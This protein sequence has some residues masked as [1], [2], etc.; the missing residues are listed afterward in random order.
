MYE[1][2]FKKGLPNRKEKY[3]WQDG[4]YYDGSW[5]DGKKNGSGILYTAASDS[6]IKGIW[7]NGEFI[8]EIVD[9]PYSIITK[10]G[11]TGVNF[12]K[13]EDLIPYRVELVFQKDGAQMRSVN[14]LSLVSSTGQIK[15]S[16]SFSGFENVTFP[17]EGYLE[18]FE[19]SRMGTT[20]IRYELRFKITEEGS[21]KV[22]VRF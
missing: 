20:M 6:S 3:I 11:V 14:Q 2:R 22:I 5:K 16:S 12:Y 9:P 17:F 10:S 4:S 18:F 21:W 13:D 15:T 1:G 8:K 7:K 19:P